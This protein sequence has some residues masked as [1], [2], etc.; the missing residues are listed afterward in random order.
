MSAL[1]GKCGDDDQRKPGRDLQYVS[2]WWCVHSR[3]T[4]GEVCWM[5]MRLL[6]RLFA[7]G[8]SPWAPSSV[9]HRAWLCAIT[10]GHCLTPVKTGWGGPTGLG[11]DLACT[12]GHVRVIYNWVVEPSTV[13][14]YS[15]N[16]P[17]AGHWAH[18]KCGDF[19]CEYTRW[20]M[21]GIGVVAVELNVENLVVVGNNQRAAL[22]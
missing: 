11:F 22:D 13:A 7:R 4:Q 18:H 19:V 15:G 12:R 10:L 16:K 6:W 20:D 2:N 3:Y 1:V 9:P 5:G 21:T 14:G 8:A 17:L